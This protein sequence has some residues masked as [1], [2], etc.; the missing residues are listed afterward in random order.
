MSN[1]IWLTRRYGMTSTKE[2]RYDKAFDKRVRIGKSRS[3]LNGLS[4]KRD[5]GMMSTTTL[6]HNG[7]KP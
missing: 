6:I 2:A 1:Y 4:W 3:I 5:L 7:Q